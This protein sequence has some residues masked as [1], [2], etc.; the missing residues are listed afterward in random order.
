M[1]DI[2][3]LKENMYDTIGAIHEVHHELGAGLNEFC[4][5]E[6]LELELT[7]RRIP[8]V[9]EKS[10][11]PTYH[12]IRMQA[13]YR[14]D[15][16]CKGNTVVECKAV[17]ALSQEHRAQLFNYMRIIECPCGILVNF[18]PQYAEIERYFFDVETHKIVTT[19]GVQL[20]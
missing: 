6:G 4:Y 10:F 2:K 17:A 7:E 8:Y 12:G 13:V 20:S 15:F 16:L 18:Y 19:T 3:R 1:L 11:H 14:V 9:R 5:Q